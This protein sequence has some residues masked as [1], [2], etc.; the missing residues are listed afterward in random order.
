VEPITV[1]MKPKN[2]AKLEVLLPCANTKVTVSGTYFNDE[3]DLYSNVATSK[4]SKIRILSSM[5]YSKI[6][7]P[8]KEIDTYEKFLD[9][10]T[11]EDTD[12][13][14]LGILGASFGNLYDNTQY[15]PYCGFLNEHTINFS[16]ALKM[17]VYEGKKFSIVTKEVLEK[18]E[19]MENDVYA[20]LKYPTL[21]EAIRTE[22]L[23]ETTG[24]GGV[25]TSPNFIKIVEYLKEFRFVTNSGGETKINKEKD[26][27]SFFATMRAMQSI[28][29][30]QLIRVINK[31]F[32][33]Y[34]ISLN[35]EISCKSCKKKFED[36]VKPT[37]L[38]F[39]EISE[40]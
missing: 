15:C 17:N 37:Q 34:N 26:H 24:K 23:L 7:S 6:I 31:E 8:P 4:S 12:A 40:S 33:E 21:N 30:K 27:M 13:V 11:I 36:S 22:E 35:T 16:S 19:N 3:C 32:S 10:C 18:L 25:V 39:R 2:V 29:R 38:F 9:L 1:L 14:L 20:L 5:A 28:N